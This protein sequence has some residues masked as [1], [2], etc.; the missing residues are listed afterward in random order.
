MSLNNTELRKEELTEESPK[1]SKKPG[2]LNS[3]QKL[4]ALETQVSTLNEKIGKLESLFDNSTTILA[5]EIDKITNVSKSIIKRLNAAITAGEGGDLS[6]DMVNKIIL[7]EAEV[8]LQNKVKMLEKAGAIIKNDDA[9][10]GKETFLVAREIDDDGNLI[11]PRTQFKV[12][13]LPDE[14]TKPMLGKKL[15]DLIKT[16]EAELTLEIL[17]VYDVKDIEV[18]KNFEEEEVVESE[19]PPTEEK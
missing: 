10:I 2:K 13:S 5:G 15:G 9:I 17:E 11:N 16:G 8:D 12:G 4:K 14:I 7:Q 6:N 19:E 3:A 1:E 18:N